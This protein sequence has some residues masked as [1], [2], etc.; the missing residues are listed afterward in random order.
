[1]KTVAIIQ[2]RMGSTRLPG[3]VLE[4]IQGRCMLLRVHDRAAQ[5]PHVDQVAVATSTQPGDAA[6][7]DLCNRHRIPCMQGS[8]S[9]V[10]DRYYQ[11]ARRL[12]AGVIVRITADC[13][14][15]DPAVSGRVVE[16][17]L[18]GG[19]DYV[20]N[21]RRRTYPRGL[22]TEVFAFEALGRAWHEAAEPY[23]REHVT[24]YIYEEKNL[25]SV[26]SVM[27]GEDHSSHRWTVDTPEDLELVRKIYT[28]F[29]HPP[30][31]DEVL[32]L[33]NR[34]PEL[35]RINQGVSQKE[36]RE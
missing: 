32:C 26:G 15:L 2:A 36:L 30:G 13:P 20:S 19:F 21:I 11:S 28:M 6:I 29:E 1:M 5:I 3:K 34:H 35:T 17:F 14:L 4:P 7:V 31:M 10:L 12:E 9:D 22:D 25:F 27:S 23:Q 24:P 8:E 33:L 16:T 18:A